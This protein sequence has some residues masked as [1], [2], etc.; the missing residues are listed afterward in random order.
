MCV[1]GT[2]PSTLVRGPARQGGATEGL[3]PIVI[4]NRQSVLRM[5]NV[6][7]PARRVACTCHE[8]VRARMMLGNY[9]GIDLF[10]SITLLER[11][12]H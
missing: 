6:Q 10:V 12:R 4:F 1:L 11:S 3:L 9:D 5:Q 2:S 7:N 8:E